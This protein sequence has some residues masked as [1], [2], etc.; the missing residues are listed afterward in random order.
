MLQHGVGRVHDGIYQCAV[1]KYRQLPHSCSQEDE[2]FV[3]NKRK[4]SCDDKKISWMEERN[5]K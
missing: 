4:Q 2:T 3:E 1:K 5:M